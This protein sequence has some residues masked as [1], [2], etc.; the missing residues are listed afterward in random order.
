MVFRVNK[1]AAHTERFCIWNEAFNTDEVEKILFLEKIIEFQN[2]KVGSAVTSTESSARKSK[3]SFLMP[4]DNTIWIFE[5]FAAIIP[6]INYDHFLYNIDDIET[7][8]YTIYSD[9]NEHYDWHVDTFPDYSDYTRK[10]S[11]TMMLSDPSEYEGG[12][13][14]VIMNSR[15]TD[16][17]FKEPKGNIVFFDS[18]FP[19]KVHPVTSGVRKSLVLWIGGKRES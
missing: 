4:N 14:E 18:M 6:K 19:H 13:L 5:R 16:N 2:G 12:E 8:Q 10:I 11:A 9:D 17:K 3:V 15:M 7:I 1:Y